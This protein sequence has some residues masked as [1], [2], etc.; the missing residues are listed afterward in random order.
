MAYKYDSALKHFTYSKE[1]YKIISDFLLSGEK[2][3]PN[4]LLNVTKISKNFGKRPVKW[5]ELS[6]TVSF[7]KALI[8]IKL[9]NGDR[10]LEQHFKKW[11]K[12]MK[13]TDVLFT[14][15]GKNTDIFAILDRLDSKRL[16]KLMKEIVTDVTTLKSRRH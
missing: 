7:A 8:R 12:S 2:S 10:K 4:I 14:D 16:L 5:L 11:I 9:Q 15:F 1:S 3:N 6:T 13:K